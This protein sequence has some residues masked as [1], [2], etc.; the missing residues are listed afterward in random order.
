MNNRD[1]FPATIVVW[2]QRVQRENKRLKRANGEAGNSFRTPV[3]RC[4]D[5]ASHFLGE[6]DSFGWINDPLENF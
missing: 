2:R 3:S 5:E 4:V 6:R 1:D